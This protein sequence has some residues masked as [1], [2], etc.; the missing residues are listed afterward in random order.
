MAKVIPAI[1][2]KP[3]KANNPRVFLFVLNAKK[4]CKKPIPKAEL[5]KIVTDTVSIISGNKKWEVVIPIA[6][7]GTP[8]MIPR[9]N[10]FAQIFLNFG[11]IFGS[12]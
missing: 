7:K 11:K 4:K 2:A 6:T 12:Y 9:P 5:A 3:D 8:I 10:V 1:N